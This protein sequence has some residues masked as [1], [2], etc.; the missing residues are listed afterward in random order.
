MTSSNGV[1]SGQQEKEAGIPAAQ[2]SSGTAT[3]PAAEEDTARIDVVKL[4]GECR[5]PH[6]LLETS[7]GKVLF[8]RRWDPAGDGHAAFLVLHGITAYSGPYGP[9]LAQEVAASG[10]RVYG[11]DLR[12]HGLSDGR[13]GDIP[14]RGRLVADLGEALALVRARNPKVILLGH[15][16]GALNA[17]VAT[18]AFPDRVDG[19]V[20]F[21][22]ARQV[23]RGVYAK[24]KG[25]AL[26]KTLLGATLLRHRPLIEYRRA[27][28]TGAGDPLFNFAYSARFMSVLF[29]APALAVARM[30]REG[31]LDSP[32]LTFRG[33]LR[34]P[35]LVGVGD[36]DELFSVEAARAFYDSIG[37][38][39][40]EFLVVPG[41]KHAAFPPGSWGPLVAWA[42]QRFP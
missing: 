21:S 34:V 40:K 38:E 5:E 20:L 42:R 12:G 3:V 41:A 24:P 8:L 32:N 26:L 29:G 6:D 35:L 11:L 2:P 15:S 31:N 39:D 13:R 19:L 10:F 16:L 25:T 36:Q 14:S 7:D 9:L 1:C 28:M 30:F 27:G 18:N 22:A 17:V 4:R 37:A 23:R 33:P